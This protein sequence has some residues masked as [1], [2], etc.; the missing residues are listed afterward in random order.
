MPFIASVITCVLNIMANF[1]LI[2]I[3]RLGVTGAAIAT[4]FSALCVVL[5]Y[6]SAFMKIF[7]DIGLEIG[8]FYISKEEIKSTLTYAIPSMMQQSIMYFCTMIVSPLTNLSGQSAIAGYTMSMKL[9]DLNAGVYQNANKTISTY[10]AQCVGAKKY[11]I[12][13]KALVL[14]F[15]KLYRF[16]RHSFTGCMEYMLRL[17]YR[18]LPKQYSA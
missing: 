15:F 11:S 9:Y 1:V 18:G 8:G 17:Y 10:V 6:I 16:L 2:K 14:H 5:F 3:C 12:I 13:K 7:G 4:I